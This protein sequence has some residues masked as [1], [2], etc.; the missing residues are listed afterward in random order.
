VATIFFKTCQ[1]PPVTI[2]MG[3]LASCCSSGLSFFLLLAALLLI[4]RS[5]SFC[6]LRAPARPFDLLRP[7]CSRLHLADPNLIII[8]MDDDDDDDEEE[9]V[10]EDESEDE[11]EEVFE[12]DPYTQVASSEF[13]SIGSVGSGMST[14]MDWGGALGKLRQRFDDIEQGKSG[15]SQTLFRLMSSQ[16]PNQAIGSFVT[17]ANPQVVQAMSGAVSALLGGLSSPTSGV[18]TIVK[19][20]G[21]KIGSLCFQLQMTGYVVTVAISGSTLSFG[22]IFPRLTFSLCFQIYVSER[23]ICDRFKRSH[24]ITR[25][26]NIARL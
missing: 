16:S 22:S 10:P 2:T 12:D 24:E 8:D 26:C 4:E 9:Y 14:T 1:L 18:E 13:S 5:Q 21:D 3:M 20:T 7:C 6:F 19:S 23:R 15:P 25:F 17:S 11:D